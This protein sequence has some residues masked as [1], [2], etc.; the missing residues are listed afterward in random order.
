MESDTAGLPRAL[1]AHEAA[2]EHA[3]ARAAA[4]DATQAVLVGH[5]SAIGSCE[6]DQDR[7]A[8]DLQE[9]AALRVPAS[10]CIRAPQRALLRLSDR[11]RRS[12][13]GPTV[14]R[15]VVWWRALSPHLP[16]K[17]RPPHHAPALHSVAR[18]N[19]HC[20]ANTG[21]SELGTRHS[22]L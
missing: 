16:A 13:P 1:A 19:L 5:V 3:D 14:A 10:Q 7:H 4:A 2:N 17:S 22:R 9:P 8:D 20:R 6:A 18:I 21:H 11:D 12:Q 15:A